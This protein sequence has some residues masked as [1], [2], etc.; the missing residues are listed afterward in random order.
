MICERSASSGACSESASRIGMSVSVSRSIPGTQPTV[1]I[2]VR[3]WVMPTSGSLVEDL[4]RGQV[5]A[6]LHRAG[7]A[8]RAGERAAG[9]RGDADRAPAVAIAHQHGLDS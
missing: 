9:L 4:G 5:A 3:R 1:E 6:E 7:G 8:E 2:P